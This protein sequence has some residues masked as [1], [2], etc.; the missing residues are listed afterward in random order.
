MKKLVLILIS[1]FLFLSAG[2]AQT[3]ILRGKVTDA[4]TGEELIGTT[5]VVTGTTK[6]TITD[7]DGISWLKGGGKH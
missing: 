3:G 6:G 2:F 1:I 5:V 7:F 4:E